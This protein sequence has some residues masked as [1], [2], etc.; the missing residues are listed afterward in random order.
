LPFGWFQFGSPLSP[1]PAQALPDNYYAVWCDPKSTAGDLL[2]VQSIKSAAEPDPLQAT[3]FYVQRFVAATLEAST[4]AGP[5]TAPKNEA[6]PIAEVSSL[7]I[8]LVTRSSHQPST[9]FGVYPATP[10]T[11]GT[12]RCQ[13]RDVCFLIVRLCVWLLVFQKKGR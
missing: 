5:V 8:S 1:R 9:C 6:I 3:H 4:I 10:H 7:G 12:G 13:G 2:L 11:T